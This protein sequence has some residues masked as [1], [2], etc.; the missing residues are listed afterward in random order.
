[1]DVL[2]AICTWSIAIAGTLCCIAG[3]L[4]VAGAVLCIAAD[5]AWRRLKELHDLVVLQRLI[6]Q[7]IKDGRFW[8]VKEGCE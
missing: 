4:S 6:R 7:L 1:M 2:S 3:L 8:T 5:R